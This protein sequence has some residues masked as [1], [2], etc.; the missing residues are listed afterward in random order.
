MT[1]IANT[2][3]VFNFVVEIAG[4]NQWEIQKVTIPEIEIEK[5][6]HGD[7]NHDIKTPG[8]VT[9]GDLV[10]E[11]IRPM[12]APDMFG[13]NWLKQAQDIQTGGGNLA[14]GYKRD[15]IIK[16]MDAGGTITLNKWIVTGAWVCKLASS[17]LDRQA[18]DNIVETLTLSVDECY[19]V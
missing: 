16:E 18:S 3:K 6:M 2:R 17:D 1:K 11:K 9:V 13:Y 14:L 15:L 4:V 19:R 10:F 8:R 7:T 12:P 5:V